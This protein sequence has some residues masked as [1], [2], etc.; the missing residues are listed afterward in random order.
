MGGM[1]PIQ[2]FADDAVTLAR[3]WF[4]ASLAE[5][6]DGANARLG[7]LVAS[8]EGLDLALRFVDRVVRPADPAVAARELARIGREADGLR[9]VVSPLDLALL[10]VGAATARALPG[11]VVPAARARLRSLVGHLVADAD[12]L[13]PHLARAAADGW[14]LNLNLLGEAVLG[15]AEARRRA[16]A[17]RDLVARPDVTHVSVKVTSVA[18][19]LVPWD[20]AGNTERVL[21]RLAP[22]YRA[23]VPGAVV[24][25]DME[26][27]QDLDLT[28]AV[29]ERV[30]ADPALA[31]LPV[32]VV[33]QAYLPDAHGAYERLARAAAARVAA[34]GAP[35]RV[36]LV[37]GANLSMEHVEADL[38]GWPAAPYPG[39]HL[40]DASYVRLLDRA[41][42]PEAAEVLRVGVASHNLFDLALALLVARDRGVTGWEV[43]MLQGMAPAQARAVRA[44]AGR[45]LLYTPVVARR[46]FD[47]AV[48]YLVRRLEEVAAP[49][50]VVGALVS[51]EPR[52]LEPHEAA[53]RAALHTP[54][55]TSPR[56][57]ARPPLPP[58]VDG[59]ANAPDT[60][61][62]TS[63][64]RA[65]AVAALR[66]DVAVPAPTVVR[67][68]ADLDAA[69]GRAV[70][71]SA[72]AATEP[73]HRARVL[74]DAGDRIEAARADLVHLMAHEAG[75]PLSE[76]DTEVSEA[77]DFARYYADRAE[78]LVEGPARFR[79][80]GVT[81]VTPP[82]N[83]P[84]AIPAGSVLAA[85]AAG[86]PV[87]AKPA[88]QV[89]RCGAL[90]L[91]L[92]GD[93]LAAHGAPA[94]TLQV[95]DCP[96]G[97]VGR[98]LVSHP[99]VARVLL[100][101]SIE[102]A[103]L[104]ESWSAHVEVIAETSGKNA[105]VVTP[106]ADVDLAV[107]DV[108]RSA[109]GHAGQKCSAA[110]LLVL[111]GSAGRDPR[112][113]R[114]LAD[115]VRS[116]RVGPAT[117]PGTQVG[118]LIEPPTGNLLRALTTLDPGERWLV[119]P[120]PLDASRRLWRPG[121]RVTRPGSFLHLTECFGPV[122]AVLRAATLDEAVDLVNATEF[123]LT[124]GIHSL[125]PAEVDRWLARVEVGNAYVNRHITG[126][127]VRRQPFGGW[128]ASAV[129][130]GAKAGG[131][132]YVA[133]LG[134]WEDEAVDDDWLARAVAH[135]T[136]FWA[137][138][139]RPQDP[140][141]LAAEHNVLRHLPVPV[142]LR[143][144]AGAR[145]REVARFRHAA[146]T[147]GA[148]LSESHEADEPA[149]VFVEAVRTGRVTGRIRAIG[150]T[151]GLRPAVR[152]RTGAVTLLDHPVLGDARRE[153]LTVVREQA[154][155]VTAHRFGHL[156]G[157]GAP[158]SSLDSG[159]LRTQVVRPGVR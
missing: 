78:E 20:L 105:I 30:L 40:T 81:V 50:N 119:E 130:S 108:V 32:G 86:S 23:A 48:A 41:L 74:R 53:F 67:T 51:R 107:A 106:A 139:S 133:A 146:A 115:A 56:R 112:I 15:E 158:G 16:A 92:V 100:T 25:L 55:D 93:A 7:A 142:T 143:V 116:L 80:H 8:P 87:L 113:P 18:A 131:P 33:L 97:E 72:W 60:D 94:G 2:D 79:P 114:Q 152:A 4:E 46:D 64:G 44:A 42:R 96:E 71:A 17:V 49:Q 88:P 151:P 73:A 124:G 61:P 110:S 85:L 47:L 6:D 58:L 45:V 138:L 149:E 54:V 118:P 10:R 70:G 153:L 14:T 38:R 98:R 82:W 89:P 13:G 21:E 59:F 24:T 68:P 65:W 129:G 122:L 148:P 11:V 83:F 127:V 75:K 76:A 22:I 156:E 19:Q 9:G 154:V 128:K 52:S 109:F 141:G 37:K 91:S 157:T 145:E 136:E 35:G 95:L 140:S 117:E 57:V 159:T 144:G 103:R 69:V 63:D 90:V 123:G 1:R 102:T 31:R 155:S 120:R 121:V 29:Y 34:G 27:Y 3:T 99:D 28:L 66:R 26:A 111:V 137:D 126:A 12:D 39:K 147:V 84:V 125:D 101:G 135:D 150:D 132:A 104:F 134:R 43:E 77:V 36:R 62:A 5:P